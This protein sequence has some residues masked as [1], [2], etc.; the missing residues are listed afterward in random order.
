MPITYN[1]IASVTVGSGGAASID[2]TSIPSTYTDLLVYISARST[3]SSVD[4]F[5]IKINNSSSDFSGRFL[6][7]NGSSASSAPVDIGGQIGIV[8]GTATTASTFSSSLLYLP[9]Y[10]GST[11]KSYSSDNVTENNA[12]LAYQLLVAGLWSQTT[13]ISSLQIYG[14]LANLAEQST[15]TL[16]GK[17]K[18]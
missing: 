13:A 8:N 15:A 3:Q 10:S 14:Q 17:K 2:F 16:Y 11:N 4:N 12:T 6:V 9:N 1:K 7:G 5:V 18:D